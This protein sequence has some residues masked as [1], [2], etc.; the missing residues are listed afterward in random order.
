MSDLLAI[1]KRRFP[2]ETGNLNLK[3]RDRENQLITVA[4]RQVSLLAG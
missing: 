2:E 3:Y 1:V 4:T